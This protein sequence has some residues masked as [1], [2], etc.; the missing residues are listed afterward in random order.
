MLS[1]YCYSHPSFVD[2]GISRTAISSPTNGKGGT[3][4]R[5]IT[6]VCLVM[7]CG[8][9]TRT[10][11]SPPTSATQGQTAALRAELDRTKL[12]LAEAKR[13]L[14]AETL[15]AV[16]AEAAAK[17]TEEI[18][19]RSAARAEKD[20]AALKRL[21]AKFRRLADRRK[22]ELHKTLDRLRELQN[23]IEAVRRKAR[24]A[25]WCEKRTAL[26]APDPDC[27]Y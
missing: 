10:V 4:L 16:A 26:T 8:P 15:R 17:R 25:G 13:Q 24:D 21:A 23:S 3:I 18:A 5:A 1:Q 22:S 9:N 7:G 12:A 27:P 20:A 11:V 19:G 14:Q 6:L 2:E